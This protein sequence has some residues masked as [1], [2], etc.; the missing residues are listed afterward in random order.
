L[1]CPARWEECKK[2]LQ[3]AVLELEDPESH[4]QT[5]TL[6]LLTASTPFLVYAAPELVMEAAHLTLPGIDGTDPMKTLLSAS[7]FV[8]LFVQVPTL[9]LSAQDLPDQLPCS[10]SHVLPVMAGRSLVPGAT[11]GDLAICTSSLPD[12]CRS[13]LDRFLE[14][15]TAM[16]KPSKKDAMAALDIAGPRLL[17]T[18]LFL[19]AK[20]GDSSTIDTMTDQL[21]DWLMHTLQPTAIKGVVMLVGAFAL[22]DPKAAGKIMD[23]A[24]K[25]LPQNEEKIGSLGESEVLWY[26]AVV[27]AAARFGGKELLSRKAS[28]EKI[29]QIALADKRKNVRNL[30]A[31]LTR[32]VLM[33]L[34]DPFT[35]DFVRKGTLDESLKRWTGARGAQLGAPS[36]PMEFHSPSAEELEFAHSLCESSLTVIKQKAE[37]TDEDVHTA[38]SLSK[39]LLRGVACLYPDERTGDAATLTVSLL[40]NKLG[41]R[42]LEEIAAFLFVLCPK[43]GSPCHPLEPAMDSSNRPKMLCKALRIVVALVRGERRPEISDMLQIRGFDGDIRGRLAPDALTEKVHYMGS[44]RDTSRA[45]YNWEVVALM[46]RRLRNRPCGFKFEGLRQKLGELITCYTFHENSLV[47]S[48]ASDCLQSFLRVHYGA[49]Q[50]LLQGSVLPLQEKSISGAS[51]SADKAHLAEAALQGWAG[52]TDRVFIPGIWRNGVAAALKVAS[53]IIRTVHAYTEEGKTHV[54]IRPVCIS[55][56]FE[57]LAKWCNAKTGAHIGSVPA[58]CEKAG[59]LLGLLRQPGTHWRTKVCVLAAAGTALRVMHLSAI[60]AGTADELDLVVVKRWISELIAG[61]SP[62]APQ[63]LT[64]IVVAELSAAMRSAMRRPESALASSLKELLPTGEG[65]LGQAAKSLAGLHQGHVGGDTGAPQEDSVQTVV[66]ASAAKASVPHLGWA[67]APVAT[68][69]HTTLLFSKPMWPSERAAA[70]RA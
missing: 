67:A 35:N 36:K 21:V 49:K 5:S 9:D 17:A 30:G 14:Y 42:I 56:Q 16:P 27:G 22:A 6:Q 59:E 54:D 13:L 41:P 28:L 34:T 19:A 68:P 57:L 44:W 20:Q 33:G 23:S 7:F 46:N 48:L 37:G 38:L 3:E 63:Q 40:P 51:T 1:L 62:S 58:A 61:F 66:R 60:T 64:S 15:V 18:A 43:L 4:R 55:M 65:F 8:N 39:S 47:S 10:L 31:K 52:A 12:L 50:T 2:F 25:K 45:W 26:L 11:S 70:T 69:G 53:A 29:I 32:R 24:L